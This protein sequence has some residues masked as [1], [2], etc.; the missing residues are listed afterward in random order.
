MNLII[1]IYDGKYCNKSVIR[2]VYLYNELNIGGIDGHKG[3]YFF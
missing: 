2:D 1:F 3:K